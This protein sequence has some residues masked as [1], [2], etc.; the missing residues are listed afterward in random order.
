MLMTPPGTLDGRRPIAHSDPD[1]ILH[2]KVTGLRV[3]RRKRRVR[4]RHGR[5]DR[6]RMRDTVP[7]SVLLDRYFVVFARPP[8]ILFAE[9]H[10][11]R[12]KS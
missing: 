9:R 4:L 5:T 12:L 8:G 2:Q 3:Q 11:S 10:G 1:E 7:L 6:E